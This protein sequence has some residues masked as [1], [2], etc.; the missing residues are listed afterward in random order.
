MSDNKKTIKIDPTLFSMTKQK[1]GGRGNKTEKKSIPKIAPKINPKSIKDK[2][3]ARIKAHKTN[4]LNKTSKIKPSL[5]K[6]NV[7]N[8][9]KTYTGGNNEYDE[10]MAYLSSLVKQNNE[11]KT[12]KRN[13]NTKTLKKF[14]DNSSNIQPFHVELSLPNDLQ[15]A[16]LVMNVAENE[17]PIKINYKIEDNGVPY[18]NLKGGMKP[19]YKS[20]NM[21]MKSK[22]AL[23]EKDKIN[24]NDFNTPENETTRESKLN[25]L[26]NKLREHQNN[27]ITQD[28]IMMEQPLI[29]NSKNDNI[30]VSSSLPISLSNTIIPST[31]NAMS[32]DTYPPIPIDNY[33]KEKDTTPIKSIT[34]NKEENSSN[35]VRIKRPNKIKKTIHRKYTLG[36]SKNK[37]EIGVLIKNTKTRKRILEAQREIKKKG[38]NDIKQYL[39]AHGLIKAG[40]N[41]PNNVIRK[42]YES[43][44]LSGEITNTNQD[45]LLHN[46]MKD[47]ENV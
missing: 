14:S 45:T 22:P 42:I 23:E 10:S 2:F 27:T 30:D 6:K 21:T 46:F 39:R 35:E 33:V 9:E 18:G 24:I 32:N 28:K 11:S 13:N 26:K 29:L 8:E 3:L 16:P 12:H 19:T 15:P 40:S 17:S 37:K 25:E 4:E 7:K 36:R 31:P 41:A 43:T 38:I 34:S 47:E 5:S 20:W 44:M 1:K